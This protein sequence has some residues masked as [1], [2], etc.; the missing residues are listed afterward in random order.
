MVIVKAGP[1]VNWRIKLTRQRLPR[2]LGVLMLTDN[3]V[4][5]NEVP[6]VDEN[7]FDTQ[8]RAARIGAHPG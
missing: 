2:Q 8:F 7:G 5:K 4:Y 3:V 1:Y 6:H